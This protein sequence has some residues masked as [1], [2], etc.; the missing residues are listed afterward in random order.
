MPIDVHP[1]LSMEC[2]AYAAPP[3]KGF[4]AIAGGVPSGGN[5]V[6]RDKQKAGW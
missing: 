4:L 2:G 5:A 1:S 6:P 3:L